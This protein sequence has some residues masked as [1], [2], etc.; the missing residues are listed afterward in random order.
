MEQIAALAR[1]PALVLAAAAVVVGMG[2]LAASA[3]L[4]GGQPDAA[5]AEGGL[6]DLGLADET[7]GAEGAAG[8]DAPGEVIVYV[9][10]AV[11][12]PDV[13]RLPAEA[14]VK[15]LVLAAGGLA[16]D[17]DADRIN[18]AGRLEDGQHVVVPRQ[19]GAAAD[20]PE[21]AAAG[22]G[23]GGGLVNINTA[24]VA[25]LEALPGIGQTT[26]ERIVEHREANG[27]FQSV[28]DLQQVR[29]IGPAALAKIAAL[30]TI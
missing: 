22:E 24:T 3:G 29:G 11:V 21:A 25:E 2:L 4:L 16:A 14:R 28:E 5:P 6:A 13:Y 1:R 8:E 20:A 10:G 23:G 27:P 18:L 7:L 15:D 12:A 9:S 30:V 19:S 26:A 17:A